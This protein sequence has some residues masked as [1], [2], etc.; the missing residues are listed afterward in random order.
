M[1]EF[2]SG[3]DALEAATMQTV[4]ELLEYATGG[5]SDKE[6]IPYQLLSG[7]GDAWY[8]DTKER[9]PVRVSRGSEVMVMSSKPD[10]QGRILVYVPHRLILVPEEDLITVGFN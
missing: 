10:S 7:S 9:I 8:Y 1:D 2:P 5:L 3:S 6:P 4:K